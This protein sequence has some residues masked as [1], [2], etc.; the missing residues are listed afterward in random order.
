MVSGFRL[1]QIVPP[2]FWPCS[3]FS[4]SHIL[5]P[6]W[7]PFCIDGTWFQPSTAAPLCAFQGLLLGR[8]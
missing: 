7:T 2:Y 4:F 8:P 5:L 6:S 3:P 1:S